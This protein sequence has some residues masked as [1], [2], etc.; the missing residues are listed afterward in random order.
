METEKERG[1]KGKLV[2]IAVEQKDDPMENILHK[3]NYNK[4]IRVTA[5]V[6]K[7]VRN[8]RREGINGPLT[9]PEITL[10]ENWWIKRVQTSLK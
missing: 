9:E 10:A 1:G 5:Y 2:K 7:F 3:Y 6:L 8:S 4:L